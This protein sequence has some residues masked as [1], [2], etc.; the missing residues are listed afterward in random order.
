MRS[1]GACPPGQ[2]GKYLDMKPTEARPHVTV[3]E[4]LADGTFVREFTPS[5][6]T[7]QVA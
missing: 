1:L 7:A 2:V 3:N 5:L 6:P 4:L